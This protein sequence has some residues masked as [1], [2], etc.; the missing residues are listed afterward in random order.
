[1]PR[2]TVAI[3]INPFSDPYSSPNPPTVTMPVMETTALTKVSD[4]SN[5]IT[6]AQPKDVGT[7]CYTPGKILISRPSPGH[8]NLTLTLEVYDTAGHEYAVC[9]L[10]FSPTS[11][12]R[13]EFAILF[14]SPTSMPSFT[15]HQGGG[16]DLDSVYEAGTKYSFVLL[17]QNAIGG[18]TIIDPQISNEP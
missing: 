16:V 11:A 7:H 9:G 18:M 10:L 14:S 1:M 8:P 13:D 17:V 15:C 6:L 2:A 3:T 12:F 4:P 5:R